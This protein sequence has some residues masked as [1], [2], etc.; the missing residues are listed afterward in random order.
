M[1]CFKIVRS[2]SNS[3]LVTWSLPK[4]KSIIVREFILT[5]G[6]GIPEEHSVKLNSKIRQF[7]I[8]NLG[9]YYTCCIFICL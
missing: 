5:W 8:N 1:Y 2:F 6:K 7:E 4:D 3:L 9:E